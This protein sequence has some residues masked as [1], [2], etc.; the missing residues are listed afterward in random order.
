MFLSQATFTKV[1]IAICCVEIF[2][3]SGVFYG[4]NSLIPIYKEEKV[5][6]QFCN[7]SS[8]NSTTNCDIQEGFFG[9][10]FYYWLVVQAVFI[11][12]FIFDR[13]GLVVTKSIASICFLGGF[14]CLA[15]TPKLNWLFFIGGSLITVSAHGIAISNISL[16]EKYCNK[17]NLIVSLF[18][19]IYDASSVVMSGIK[20]VVDT[21]LSIFWVCTGYGCAGAAFIL[22]SMLF[23]MRNNNQNIK[24]KESVLPTTENTLEDNT[25]QM[26]NKCKAFAD[27]RYT[28]LSK[29][30]F[31]KAFIFHALFFIIILF[32][33]TFFLSQMSSQL[34]YLFKGQKNVI[35]HILSISNFFFLG[36]L[37]ISPLYGYLLDFYQNKVFQSMVKAC[38]TLTDQEVYVKMNSCFFLP[39]LICSLVMIVVSSLIYIPNKYCFYMV[40][41]CITITRSLLFAINYSYLL[42]TFP[43]KYFGRLIGIVFLMSGLIN[44]FLQDIIQFASYF[45]YPDITNGVL[46]SLCFV[47]LIQVV[48]LKI[49]YWNKYYYNYLI[50]DLKCNNFNESII[51]GKY[52]WSRI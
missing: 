46:L 23:A 15:L 38:S 12:G 34:F 52:R 18:S 47:S 19:G 17:K 1:Y 49:V 44:F 20:L 22:G 41:V 3:F 4:F 39:T 21:G 48:Y 11:L 26:K 32:R 30:F 6:S 29:C 2:F 28:T 13:F 24:T 50:C 37:L 5:F 31:S 40:L 14:V 8:N 27:F 35:D 9:S 36:S 51:C 7:S 10:A 33:F 45:S 43:K 16:M 42:C 25:N